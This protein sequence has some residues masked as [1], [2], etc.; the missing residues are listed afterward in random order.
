MPSSWA[1]LTTALTMAA[2]VSS[3][4]RRS[5]KVRSILRMSTG[6]RWRWVSEL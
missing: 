4:V 3:S 6:K 1:R 5:T 2:A